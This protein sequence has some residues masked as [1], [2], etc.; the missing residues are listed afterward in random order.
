MVQKNQDYDPFFS[1]KGQRQ[2]TG[3]LAAKAPRSASWYFPLQD[4]E[5]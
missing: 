5:N 1:E 3:M 2:V 4:V